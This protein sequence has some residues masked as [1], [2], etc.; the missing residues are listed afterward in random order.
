MKQFNRITIIGVGLIGGSIGLA[1][2]KRHLAKEVVG[3]FRHKST[4][5]KALSRKAVDRA[6]M[7]MAGGV[8]GADLIIVASPVSSIPDLVRNAMAY[9][10]DGA[11]ITDV[12]STKSWIAKEISRFSAKFHKISFIGS[13]PMA[14]SERAGVE[15]AKSDLMEGSPCIVMKARAGS[16]SEIGRASCRERV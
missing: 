13:H 3:V 16:A 15:F 4:M 5:R 9:A 6:T 2:R 12:G 14:G 8:K 7:D 11:V 1:A 10:K